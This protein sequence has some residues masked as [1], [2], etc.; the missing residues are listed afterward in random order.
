M[1][2]HIC[3]SYY[4]HPNRMASDLPNS[5]RTLSILSGST[6]VR[7]LS[8]PS[9]PKAKSNRM[10][11]EDAAAVEVPVPVPVVT[12]ASKRLSSSHI[13][14]LSSRRIPSVPPPSFPGVPVSS[15]GFVSSKTREVEKTT[16]VAG[17]TRIVRTTSVNYNKL[18]NTTTTHS[19]GPKTP[20]RSASTSSKLYVLSTSTTTP[21]IHQN[22]RAVAHAENKLDTSKTQSVLI[23]PPKFILTGIDPNSSSR[24][25]TGQEY[26]SSTRMNESSSAKGTPPKVQTLS[27]DVKTPRS[28]KKSTPVKEQMQISP[29]N[30]KKKLSPMTKS[31]SS[32]ENKTVLSKGM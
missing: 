18:S 2:D 5:R 7:A 28:T 29:S 12:L 26:L 16:S 20:R 1:F 22:K 27:N 9:R 25:Q 24:S 32:P 19:T 4:Q 13:P 17:S 31:L 14:S 6:T 8:A 21:N 23:P 10:E 30:T 15:N 3:S 11:D